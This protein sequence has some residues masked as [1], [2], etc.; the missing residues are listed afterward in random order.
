MWGQDVRVW[1]KSR[2]DLISEL[3]EKGHEKLRYRGLLA[4]A[5]HSYG[6]RS[7]EEIQGTYS[8]SLEILNKIQ[9]EIGNQFISFGDTPTASVLESF[10][11]IDELRCGNFVYYD[12]T[13]NECVR[14]PVI[15]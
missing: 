2:V 7:E 14:A 6:A 8:D 12:L 3:V 13:Q 9:E 15:K 4:H 10:P 1:I 11:G 5:G